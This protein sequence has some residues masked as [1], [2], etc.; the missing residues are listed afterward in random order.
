MAPVSTNSRSSLLKS[1]AKKLLKNAIQTLPREEES[2]KR[3]SEESQQNEQK[4]RKIEITKEKNS[5]KAPVNVKQT[6]ESLKVNNSKKQNEK[7][8]KNK[9]KKTNKND[10]F[11]K[12][13][14][15]LLSADQFVAQEVDSDESDESFEVSAAYDVDEEMKRLGAEDEEPEY[16][17]SMSDS[18]EEQI[19]KFKNL[20]NNKFNKNIES[21]EDDSMSESS[22]EIVVKKKRERGVD[23]DKY[24]LKVSA[25]QI[26]DSDEE[27]DD[28][29]GTQLLGDESDEDD[30]ADP[31]SQM[32]ASSKKMDL[33]KEEIERD[34]EKELESMALKQEETTLLKDFEE[35]KNKEEITPNMF[36]TEDISQIYSRIVENL[37]VLVNFK[38]S[39]E[40][41]YTRQDYI[42]LLKEDLCKYYGYLPD[43]VDKFATM[44]SPPEL[45][46]L[47]EANEAP[48]PVVLRTNPLKARRREVAEALIKRGVNLDPLDRWSS[49]G[50][51]VND[52]EVPVGATPEYLAGWYMIQGAS[53]FLPVIALSP[54]PGDV[55]VDMASAPGGK[56]T[57]MSALMK[58]TGVI[59]AN[60][61]E[62]K[63]TKGLTANIHRLGV[64]NAIVCNYDGRDLPKVVHPR[65]DKILLDAPCSG[66]GIVS[67][68]PSVK[69]TRDNK[70]I[71]NMSRLQKELLL[72]AID[73]AKDPTK[74]NKPVYIVYS[75][76]SITPEENE[77]VVSYALRKRFIK[78][79]D[80]GLPKK[81]G[82][83]GYKKVHDKRFDPSMELTRRIYPHAHNMDGFFV[84]KLQKLADGLKDEE[85]RQYK[86][87]VK[88]AKQE[89][90]R[91]IKEEN[92][93]IQLKREE[94]NKKLLKVAL[95]RYGGNEEAAHQWM[96]ERKNRIL[97]DPEYKV[98]RPKKSRDS[99]R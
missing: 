81:L 71:Q 23:V 38:K 34:A 66:T 22:E 70:D 40:E 64:R 88:K 99:F 95:E 44:F 58:N 68:D 50:L 69:S 92:L 96:K 83:P 60:D 1:Q 48:R 82:K 87:D 35:F 3:K 75:T 9:S 13:D 24:K 97:D 21:D 20:K 91:S 26:E 33:E 57:Y 5:T 49:L 79:V 27:E 39:K 89:E 43:L 62:K 18:S 78:V 15:Q 30:E 41:G 63:R 73:T 90:R 51:K 6:K 59:Y 25:N 31:L 76:C 80:T 74:S 61:P 29:F 14:A 37:R 32:I 16:D 42:D 47:L 55:V 93:R 45:V 7:I 84:C 4:R 17:E 65:A 77:E 86:E 98:I 2:K 52:T 53:S 10:K 85:E 54:E 94:H 56:T 12:M 36:S 67:R 19:S 11:S 72:A 8:E 28:E 46:E